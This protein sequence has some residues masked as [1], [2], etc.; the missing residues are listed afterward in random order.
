MR[1]ASTFFGIA[2]SSSIRAAFAAAAAP[3]RRRYSTTLAL[4]DCRQ[5]AAMSRSMDSLTLGHRGEHPTH[6]ARL[7]DHGPEDAVAPDRHQHHRRD[8]LH[9]RHVGRIAKQLGPPFLG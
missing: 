5:S 9:R 3:I 2:S 1:A 6:Q 7:A 4:P 8:G